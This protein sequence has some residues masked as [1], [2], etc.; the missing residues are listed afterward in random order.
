MLLAG[1]MF[2]RSLNKHGLVTA[3]MWHDIKCQKMYIQKRNNRIGKI[4]GEWK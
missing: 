3:R 1:N 4:K 2:Q